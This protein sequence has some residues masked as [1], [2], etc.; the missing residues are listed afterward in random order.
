MAGEGRSGVCLLDEGRDGRLCGARGPIQHVHLPLQL[1]VAAP[2]GRLQH[3]HFVRQRNILLRVVR[4]HAAQA[5]ALGQTSDQE[6]FLPLPADYPG[7]VLLDCYTTERQ[8][9]IARAPNLSLSLCVCVCLCLSLS[10]SLSLSLPPLS[11]SLLP[12]CPLGGCTACAAWLARFKIIME[13]S[14]MKGSLSAQ[15]I[16]IQEVTCAFSYRNM[17]CQPSYV[18]RLTTC[19]APPT[20]KHVHAQVDTHPQPNNRRMHSCTHGIER[21]A[22]L[23]WAGRWLEGLDNFMTTS[24]K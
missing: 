7:V 6:G 9:S 8:L 15:C 16:P 21:K 24:W 12:L 18:I 14:Q 10:L 1:V 2:Q 20:D 19:A 13:V 4:K 17:L 3:A 22:R 23:N 11:L 5:G